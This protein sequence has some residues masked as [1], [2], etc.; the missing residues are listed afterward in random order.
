MNTGM[1]DAQNLAWKLALVAGGAPETVL[2]TYEQER[3][4]VT[5]S[6][7][8]L[9]DTL[10]R[11]ATLRHPVKK[12]LRDTLIPA[13]TALPVVQDRAA[14][15]LSQVS[16]AYPASPLIRPDGIRRGPKPGE[17]FP[18]IE[19]RTGRGN[20]P[21]YRV[22]GCGRHVLLVRGAEIRQAVESSGLA[23]YTG[24]VDIMDADL[25][26]AHRPGKDASAVFALVR[27]DGVLVARG[28]RR[29]THKV[30]DYLRQISAADAPQPVD[31]AH[32]N[33]A[34][35]SPAMGNGHRHEGSATISHR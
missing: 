29:D 34:A 21:L 4:P 12:A 10:I 6:V 9:T 2:D 13:A 18:D 5:T 14:R 19:V 25:R 35:G 24:L 23:R 11:L 7:L 8:G 15:R 30:I 17:R 22:L 26:A 28:A 16:V 27:P 32:I 3:V 20:T 1:L 31:L 33:G